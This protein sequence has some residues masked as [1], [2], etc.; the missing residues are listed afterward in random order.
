MQESA[1]RTNGTTRPGRARGF[2]RRSPIDRTRHLDDS[3]MRS[4]GAHPD[5]SWGAIEEVRTPPK[6]RTFRRTPCAPPDENYS[7]FT[8]NQQYGDAPA[9]GAKMRQPRASATRIASS[10]AIGSAWLASSKQGNRRHCRPLLERSQAPPCIQRS[11]PKASGGAL[12][13]AAQ[14]RQATCLLTGMTRSERH[15]PRRHAS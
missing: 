1:S 12:G 15:G 6:S 11:T 8:I 3:T 2:H 4:V 14:P 9:R 10:S 13:P 5:T 7:L